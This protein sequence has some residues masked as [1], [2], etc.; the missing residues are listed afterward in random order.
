M[1]GLLLSAAP[2]AKIALT[3]S[4]IKTVI[5]IAPPAN[6]IIAIERVTFGFFGV[7]AT[8]SPVECWLRLAS[9]DGTATSMTIANFM[10]A[11][12][13]PS[14][15]TMQSVCKHTYTVEPTTIAGILLATAVHPQSGHDSFCF[16]DL[17]ILVDGSDTYP[18]FVMRFLC[19]VNTSVL[20]TI[21][22]R[23]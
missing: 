6:R 8:D 1:S 19:G 7:A 22:F 13:R 15:S 10:A 11:K 5:G 17:N 3:A 21:W 16:P 23:E 14:N 4:V 20:P 12:R 2:T 18:L 9:N